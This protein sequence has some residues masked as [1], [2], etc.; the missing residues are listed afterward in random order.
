MAKNKLSRIDKLEMRTAADA[1][2]GVGKH[3]EACAVLERLAMDSPRNPLIWNDLGVQYEAAGEIDR[4]FAALRRGHQMDATF[5]PTLYNLGKFTLDRYMTLQEAGAL[6]DAEGHALLREAIGFLN[7][8]LDRDPE[9][10]DGHHCIALAYGLLG[11]ETMARGHISVA[12]RLR[13]Q[14]ASASNWRLE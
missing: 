12:A 2:A 4:A 13:K 7:A 5:P 10:V 9:N 1:L 14:L 3:A 6:D 11:N 8:N